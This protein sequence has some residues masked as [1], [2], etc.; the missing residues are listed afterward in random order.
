MPRGHAFPRAAES[1]QA[2]NELSAV[3][4]GRS[5]GASAA[6]NSFHSPADTTGPVPAANCPSSPTSERGKD[7]SGCSANLAQVPIHPT[8]AGGKL[9]A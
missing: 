8:P 2:R 6:L 3:D 9:A 7:A 5:S 1:A 4:R